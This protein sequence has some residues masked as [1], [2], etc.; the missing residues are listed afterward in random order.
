MLGL[1]ATQRGGEWITEFFVPKSKQN[2]R[3]VAERKED[4]TVCA[5]GLF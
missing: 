5:E 2:D 1:L 4:W 3:G